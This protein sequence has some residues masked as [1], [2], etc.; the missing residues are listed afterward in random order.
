MDFRNDLYIYDV[1]VEI[2][3]SVAVDREHVRET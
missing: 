3:L 1:F 2:H